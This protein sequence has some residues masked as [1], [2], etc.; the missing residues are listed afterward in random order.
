MKI[1]LRSRLRLPPKLTAMSAIGSTVWSLSNPRIHPA[2][3]PTA[4]PRPSLFLQQDLALETVR[5]A[6]EGALRRA[7]VVDRAVA[8]SSLD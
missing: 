8:G 1:L 6:K 7:K 4:L 2:M 3:Q 5:I